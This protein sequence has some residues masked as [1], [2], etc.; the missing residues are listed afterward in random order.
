MPLNRKLQGIMDGRLVKAMDDGEN[1]GFI[2]VVLR[3]NTLAGAA[4][5]DV[6][7]TMERKFTL[8]DVQAKNIGGAGPAND[9]LTI[10]NGSNAVTDV[11]D[12]EGAENLIIRALSIDDAHHEIAAG[13]TLNVIALDH[14]GGDQRAKIVYITG[15]YSL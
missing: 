11:M 5:A 15:Y 3:V 10:K 6:D 4:G 2:P 9:T 12:M 13:S 8:I 1:F 7:L 14:T